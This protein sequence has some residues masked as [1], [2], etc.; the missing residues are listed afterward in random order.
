MLPEIYTYINDKELDTSDVAALTSTLQAVTVRRYIPKSDVNNFIQNHHIDDKLDEICDRPADEAATDAPIPGAG[1]FTLR[2][3]AKKGLRWLVTDTG[4]EVNPDNENIQALT[5]VL[6]QAGE[7]DIALYNEFWAL[8][9][10]PRWPELQGNRKAGEEYSPEDIAKAQAIIRGALNTPAIAATAQIISDAETLDSE[11]TQA[12]YS[13]QSARQNEIAALR[14]V[15]DELSAGG[16]REVP[17]VPGG[18]VWE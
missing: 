10:T 4:P 9:E 3:I 15:L 18:A 7:I 17:S 5:G 12:E 1:G 13:R 16:A 14:L 11:L 2:Q 6:V 8:F